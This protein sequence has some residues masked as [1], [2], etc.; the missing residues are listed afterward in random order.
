VAFNRDQLGLTPYVNVPRILDRHQSMLKGE[1]TNAMVGPF[2]AD[3]SN[4]HTIHSRGGMFI[5]VELVDFLLGKDLTSRDAYLVV[6]PLLEDND[7]LDMCPPLLE[8]LQVASTQPTA[9]NTRPP[10]LQDWLG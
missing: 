8:F 9:G 3:E 1:P 10:T 4:V 6:Y 5:K 7:M 2:E